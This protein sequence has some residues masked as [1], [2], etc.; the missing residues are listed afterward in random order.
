[1]DQ[2]T[3]NK[4]SSGTQGGKVTW[5]DK[6]RGGYWVRGI[7]QVRSDGSYFDLRGQVGNHSSKPPSED[8]ADWT[9]ETWS[10]D[11]RYLENK[12]CGF[13]LVEVGE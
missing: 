4:R 10:I 7:E 3:N 9:R 12:E 11:G 6:T 8:P 5:S 13:D 1:M 2:Q